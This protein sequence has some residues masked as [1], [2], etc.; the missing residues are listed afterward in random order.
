MAQYPVQRFSDL[1][2]QYARDFFGPLIR[3]PALE[4]NFNPRIEVR[5]T[6]KRFEVSAELPGMDQKDIEVSLD[7]NN[8]ILTGERKNE[9]K[10]E[11]GGR[12]HSEFSYGSFY[13]S[14]PLGTDVDADK[15]DAHFKNGIL[16]VSVPKS[17]TSASKKIEIKH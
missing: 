15:V 7:G 2:D 12:Y 1:F 4:P 5:E 3:E 13:R 14:I 8:L 17:E 10:K 6:I 11:E 9:W 16:K